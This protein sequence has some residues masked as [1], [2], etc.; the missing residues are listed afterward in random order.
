[1]RQKVADTQEL[2]SDEDL[3]EIAGALEHIINEINIAGTLE[4]DE[5]EDSPVEGEENLPA[6]G[7]VRGETAD[8]WGETSSDED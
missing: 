7:D 8:V 5:E 6:E 3:L 4:V 1:M 2:F